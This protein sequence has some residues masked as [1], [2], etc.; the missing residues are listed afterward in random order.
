MKVIIKLTHSIFM[1]FNNIFTIFFY[2][3]K[4]VSKDPSAKYYPSSKERLQKKLV[5]DIQVFLKKKKKK[6]D[7]VIVNDTK[8]YQKMKSKSLLSKKKIL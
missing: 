5:K 3:Y 7:N 1:S 8:I 4:V 6:S 2:I